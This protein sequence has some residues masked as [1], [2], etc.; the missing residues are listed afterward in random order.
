MRTLCSKCLFS[1]YSDSPDSCAMGIVSRIKNIYNIDKDENNFNIINEYKCLYGFDL[2][3]YDENKENIGP[4]DELTQKI[5]AR[6]EVPYYIVIFLEESGIDNLIDSI[7]ALPIKP[8]Y[9]SIVVFANNNTKT[10]IEK[11]Q[12]LNIVCEWKLHNFILEE[13]KE[14]TLNIIFDTNAFNNNSQYIWVIDHTFGIKDIDKDINDINEIMT[15]YKPK[16]HMLC[17]T[18]TFSLNG[19]FISF[20][21]FKHLCKENELLISDGIQNTQGNILVYKY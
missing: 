10:I 11:L 1:D 13:S 2:K 18:D 15:I 7:Q 21:N 9:V 17:K 20:E 14:K 6:C 8:K 16:T 4:I 19:L 12:K 3:T 5:Y